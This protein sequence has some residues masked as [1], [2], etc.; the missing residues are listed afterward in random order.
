VANTNIVCSAVEI[1]KLAPP[2][3]QTCVQYLSE[4]MALTG[5]QL[6]NPN[7]TDMC[8]VCPAGSTNTFL[9]QL[10]IHYE[11][12]WRNIGLLFVFI[13]FNIVAAIG[14]YWLLRVPKKNLFKKKAKKE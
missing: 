3:G 7:A 11:D 12:R 6:I 13:A 2:A 10:N 9:A 4:Y 1:L 14:L 8:E 5:G